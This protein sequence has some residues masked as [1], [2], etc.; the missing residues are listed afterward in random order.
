[1]SAVARSLA[2]SSA[3]DPNAGGGS[4]DRQ[5]KDPP[6]ARSSGWMFPGISAQRGEELSATGV[7]AREGPGGVAADTGRSVRGLARSEMHSR[8]PTLYHIHLIGD[9][10]AEEELFISRSRIDS[11][12][13]ADL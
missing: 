8:I 3:A 4:R 5:R 12:W 10:F 9:G 1:M 2:D 11:P 6:V 7:E 13:H